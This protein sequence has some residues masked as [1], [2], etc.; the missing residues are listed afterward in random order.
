MFI[1]SFDYPPLDGGIARLC[2][3]LAAGFSRR[4]VP[5]EALSKLPGA[6]LD[7]TI[8]TTRVTRLR[9]LMEASAFRHLLARRRNGPVVCGLWY[10]EGVLAMLAGARPRVVLAH[11]SELMPARAAWRRGLWR[12]MLRRTLLGADL[13]VANSG[14]TKGLVE[15]AAPGCRAVAI[16][17]A[18]DHIRFSPPAGP[19]GRAASRA[20]F[21][22]DPSKRVVLTVS[23]L[24]RYKGHETIFHALTSLEEPVRRNFLLLVA[25]RGSD[26]AALRDAAARLGVADMVRWLGYVPE[27]DLPDLYRAAD[28]FVLCTREDPERQEVEGFGLV[29]LEAQACGTPAVGARTGGIPDAIR[30]GDGGFLIAQDDHAALTGIF[31]RL[32]ERPGEFEAIGRAARARIER[33]CTWDGYVERFAREL[34]AAGVALG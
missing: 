5:T 29:F 33:E 12:R 25:G 16:P 24:K 4:G 32:A 1:F 19:A 21:G 34:E 9:P 6:G 28:I 18:V 20:K 22:L 23:R 30:D 26:E 7:S 14:Y 10:P 31:R 27:S 8:P 13:V 2:S 11:G 17:L 15:A 3:E